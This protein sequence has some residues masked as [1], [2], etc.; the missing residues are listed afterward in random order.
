MKNIFSW[1]SSRARSFSTCKRKYYFQYY[2]HWGGWLSQSDEITKKIY[3]LKK[4]SSIPQIIGLII[5]QQIENILK[6]LKKGSIIS[7]EKVLKESI[8]SFKKSW[9]ESKSKKWKKS[10]KDYTN[11][12]EHFYKEEPSRE[13]LLKVKDKIEKC[14]NGFYD[15]D[16]FKF[17]K[18]LSNSDVLSIE[19]MSFFDFED[20]KIYVNLDFA[21][22]HDGKI[23][24]YDW[25]TGQ[26]VEE[27]ERQ[28]S[29][30]AIY[31]NQRWDKD[32]DLIRLFD[33]YI[34][35]NL[36]VKIKLNIRSIHDTKKYVRNSIKEMHS[37]L[38]DV[39]KN[40][41]NIDNFP[42]VENVNICKKCQYKSLCFGD[43]WIGL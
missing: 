11:L 38:D 19:Q 13:N 32:F 23:Y 35:R 42:M 40:I 18:Q 5:H 37:M 43:K 16:S 15:S 36:P 21:V 24:I 8:D 2:G 30:Y 27:D 25:K 26:R 9:N 6:K 28:L 20:T 14:I 10:P 1:S 17:I 34:F 39:G 3:F 7:R 4:M 12:Y 29:I 33:V 22:K 31:A 41:A